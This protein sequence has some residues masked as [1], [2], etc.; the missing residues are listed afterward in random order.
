MIAVLNG[1]LVL[2]NEIID[3]GTVLIE[4]DRI[5]YAGK[6]ECFKSE[7]FT[8]I[9]ADNLYIS[10]GFI[11][12]HCHGGAGYESYVDARNMA[13]AHLEYGTTSIL[14]TIAYNV[15]MSDI[16]NGISQICELIKRNDISNIEGIHLEGPYINKKYGAASNK[17][18]EINANDY[19][20]I[21]KRGSGKILL[22][23]LAPELSDIEPLINALYK[24]DIIIS[25]GH[26][27]AHA[28]RIG[29]FIPKGL[30]NICHIN[31]AMT[32]LPMN[33]IGCTDVGAGA[34]AFLYDELYAEVIP[35][36]NGIHAEPTMLQLIYKIKGSD[37]TVII[38]DGTSS[39]ALSIKTSLQPEVEIVDD[40]RYVNG[41][42]SG[43]CL[44]MNQ[45]VRN[46]MIHTGCSLLNA[47]KCASLTPARL[48]GLDNNI[49]SLAAGKFANLLIFDE[50][51]NIKNV[52]L[53]GKVI[54]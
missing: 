49:G 43:S 19:E 11:D 28:T 53:K 13:R 31:N 14:P 39:S 54:I 21:I 35:D 26:T 27:E 42:L 23:T 38:T 3:N 51:I 24:H 1:K 12:I 36:V 17:A 40:L 50:Q 45:A 22:W 47:V 5:I 25:A 34:A 8:V 52:I 46:F 9:N 44:T 41:E 30:K 7:G 4:N 33:K 6:E 15:S 18:V 48:L 29:S 2:E 32:F 37:K 20:E 16:M 10:P